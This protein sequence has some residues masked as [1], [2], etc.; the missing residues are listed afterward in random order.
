MQALSERSS[1]SAQ[2]PAQGAVVSLRKIEAGTATI[3]LHPLGELTVRQRVLPL[4][5]TITRFG[6]ARLDR[7]RRYDLT[8]QG[9]P[10]TNPEQVTDQFAP[11]QFDD[12]TDDQ[13]LSAPPFVDAKA[14]LRVRA[15]GEGF[16]S[17]LLGVPF[18]YETVLIDELDP[19]RPLAPPRTRPGAPYVMQD[20]TFAR[21]WTQGAAAR[22]ATRQTGE[23]KFSAPARTVRLKEARFAL[24]DADDLTPA[25]ADGKATGLDFMEAIAKAEKEERLEVVHEFELVR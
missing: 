5:R 25:A 17:G 13:K 19:E 3:M 7:A 9:L 10:A 11:A 8:V 15:T 6:S 22:A 20:T 2:P 24:A 12:L 18:G 1:W 14:G 21:L 4:A 23:E 16:P